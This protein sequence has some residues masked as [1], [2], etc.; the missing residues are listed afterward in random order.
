MKVSVITASFNSAATLSGTME[1]VLMQTYPDIEYIVIDG[2]STDGTVDI[3]KQYEPRFKGRLRWISEKDSGIYDA[4]NKGL[5][6]ATGDI[7]G[8]L[9]S[10]D[11]YYD[12]RVVADIV[13]TFKKNDVESIYGD[14]VFVEANN[15][16][17]IVRTWKGSQHTPGAF[18]RGWH[19]AHPTF[20]A[21]RSCYERFGNF[22][23]SLA[24]SSDF[25]LMLRFIEKHHISNLYIPRN[26]I[27]MRAGGE[28]N[29]SLRRILRGNRNILRSFRKNG[30]NVS[31]FYLLRRW[32]PKAWN[33]L[34]TKAK[35][36]ASKSE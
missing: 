23:T 34:K 20:Y 28:S 16:N 27:W 9:N 6:M 24:I 10:D 32:T 5:A 2:A 26:I 11:L 29:G 15:T 8:V 19:P 35:G 30:F 31:W 17:H 12:E 7:V 33:I 4:M 13:E 1:T 18:L 21:R 3:I 36:T 22:D 14:L 25:D